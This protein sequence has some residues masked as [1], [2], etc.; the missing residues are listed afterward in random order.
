MVIVQPQEIMYCD[1]VFYMSYQPPSEK[2]YLFENVRPSHTKRF[3]GSDIEAMDQPTILCISY[4]TSRRD[5][6]DL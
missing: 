5:M 2:W 3:V 1:K 6:A 4:N